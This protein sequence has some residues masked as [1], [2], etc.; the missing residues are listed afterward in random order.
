[1]NSQKKFNFNNNGSVL[2]IVLFLVIIIGFSVK[3]IFKTSE[4]LTTKM[5]LDKRYTS[6]SNLLYDLRFLIAQKKNCEQ[7]FKL[8]TSTVSPSTGVVNNKKVIVTDETNSPMTYLNINVKVGHQLLFKGLSLQPQVTQTSPQIWSSA[9]RVHFQNIKGSAKFYKEIPVNINVNL[10]NSKVISCYG[11]SGVSEAVSNFCLSLGGV[12][13][14]DTTIQGGQRCQISSNTAPP[15]VLANKSI[16]NFVND[17]R[18]TICNTI[19]SNI[20]YTKSF[21]DLCSVNTPGDKSDVC[22]GQFNYCAI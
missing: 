19:K 6:I 21:N 8:L 13:V 15:G 20:N 14:N 11:K 10:A 16:S 17:Y 3:T 7:T 22:N 4:Q 18:T 1:M 5:S 9:V 12:I 2:G